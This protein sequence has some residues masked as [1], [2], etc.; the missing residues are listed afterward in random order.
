[1]R[2]IL[3]SYNIYYYP[4]EQGFPT[5]KIWIYLNGKENGQPRTIKSL[6]FENVEN[7]KN[8]ILNNM[9]YHLYWIEKKAADFRPSGMDIHTFRKELM[10]RL[11]T[12]LRNKLIEKL[13]NG[14]S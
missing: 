5:S 13:K 1:M 7:H 2:K 14:K 3:Q 9:F 6:C 12:D 10:N 4:P 8:F 11:M